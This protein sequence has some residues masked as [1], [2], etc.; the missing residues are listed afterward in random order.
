M[1]IVQ[2]SATAHLIEGLHD[3]PEGGVAVAENVSG[4]ADVDK[5]LRRQDLRASL[6]ARQQR[7]DEPQP[8]AQ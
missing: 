5:G 7:T 6:V 4:R 1:T 8:T 3:I 2:S